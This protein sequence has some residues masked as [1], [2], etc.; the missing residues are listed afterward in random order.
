MIIIIIALLIIIFYYL[1]MNN[2]EC[3]KFEHMDN[4]GITWSRNTCPYS[5]NPTLKN[6]LLNNNITKSS[7]N[8][9][10]Y[11][12]CA[13][14][15]INKEIEMMPKIDGV[16]YFIIEG[17]DVMVAK[18][19]LWQ[20]VVGYYGIE[21]AIK[22]LP[23][24]YMLAFP[25]DVERLKLEYDVN[26]IYIMKKNVQRQEGLK[27]TNNKDEIINGYKSKYILVQELLQDPYLIS[28]RKTNM[29]LYLLIIC[30]MGKV[31]AFVYNDGFMY[32][33]KDLFVKNSLED[34]PNITTG[35]IDRQVYVDNPLTLNDLRTY[36]DT[37]RPNMTTAEKNVISQGYKLSDYYFNKI[38]VMLRDVL[39]A[40]VGKICSGKNFTDKQFTYQLF[41]VDVAMSDSLNP[42]IMEINKGPDMGSKD[43]RDGAVKTGVVYN[44]LKLI[45]AVKADEDEPNNF[46]KLLEEN[47]KVS[48]E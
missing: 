40:F 11:F 35:Y 18:E 46:I 5:M 20:T 13:Y 37:N 15:E 48:D 47:N 44:T 42:T 29:R 33:T 31:S 41:G 24:S 1:L 25:L 17:G 39:M 21:N 19:W 16:K 23:R 36:L 9:D 14:D 38:Y 3:N 8:F 4:N 32:Y 26:K 7:N 2:N 6:E 22:Y 30:Y 12:P 34:G 10:L 45:G 28:G 27:I 43:E